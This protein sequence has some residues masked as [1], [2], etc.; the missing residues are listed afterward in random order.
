MRRRVSCR[1][2]V[3][4]FKQSLLKRKRRT[5]YA[6]KRFARLNE[7]IASTINFD[8]LPESVTLDIDT[9]GIVHVDPNNP[10]HRRWLED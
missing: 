5:M 2:S 9:N 3:V 7:V 4:H 10:L 6:R 1:K 8:K